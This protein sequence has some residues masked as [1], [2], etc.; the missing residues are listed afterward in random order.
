MND[1]KD[2]SI[3]LKALSGE[4]NNEMFL[5]TSKK[6]E[7]LTSNF[8]YSHIFYFGKKKK[9]AGFKRYDFDF[10]NNTDG[11]KRW[12][13]PSD[14]KK[15]TFLNFYN[16]SSLKS[17][18]YRLVLSFC[19]LLKL[20]FLIRS[21]RFSFFSKAEILPL[22]LAQKNGCQN[23]SIFTGTVGPN[24]KIVIELNDH[25][26]SKYFVKIPLNGISEDL[27]K[28]ELSTL[29]LLNKLKI[30]KFEIPSMQ[31][32]DEFKGALISNV[33]PDN[34]NESTAIEDFHIEVLDDLYKN[35]KY[36]YT[37]KFSPF[38]FHLKS[39]MERAE[40]NKYENDLMHEIGGNLNKLYSKI[41]RDKYFI[42]GLSHGDFTPWN[43]YKKNNKLFI[44]DWELSS[45]HRP[46][47]FDVFHY[48]FQ[49]E[50]LL[51]KNNF[52]A[53][54]TEIDRITKLSSFKKISKKYSINVEANYRLYLLSNIAYYLNIYHKQGPLHKQAFWLME[55]W[56]DALKFEIAQASAL[57]YREEFIIEFFKKIESFNYVILKKHQR[58]SE[59]I[60]GNSD[61][62]ILL[63]K[64]DLGFFVELVNGSPFIEKSVV[65]KKSFMQTIMIYF[66]DGSYLSLDLLF[67]FK[68]KSLEYLEAE[69][70]LHHSIMGPDQLK[71][72]H[73]VSDFEYS[74]LFYLLN[75]KD[76][77]KRHQKFFL[78]LEQNDQKILFEY[79]NRK[80]EI[81]ASSLPDLFENHIRYHNDILKKIKSS[82]A[83][84]LLK[85]L[86]NS[87]MY[88]I[89][90]FK[91]LFN[92]QSLTIS[93]SGVDG[94]GKSTIINEVKNHLQNKYR[95]RVIVLRHRPQIIPI[96]SSF[97]YGRKQ[98]ELMAAETLPR[99][100]KN[101]S[102]LGSF[103]RFSYYFLDYLFGQVY[104]FVRY[105]LRDYIILYD[106]FYFDFINDDKR[107]NIQLNSSFIKSLYRFLLKPS[108]NIFL[109]AE[110]A[111]I[112]S[113][114]QE[115]D[116]NEISELN[117][118]YIQLFDSY[119]QK[120]R[121]EK[122]ISIENNNKSETLNLIINEYLKLA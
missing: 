58:L 90:L 107:S 84:S 78:E 66:K 77:D 92:N 68:R 76:T 16:N 120:S 20:K 14:L 82:V 111:I 61:I 3:L 114:K 46:L 60:K 72:P 121:P 50:V 38:Y 81:N 86:R 103:L 19:F 67:A 15:A 27:I 22:K 57:S 47:L 75:R 89:D 39:M 91:Q 96:L 33:K 44:Y 98:A 70:V 110:P 40:N 74:Y 97:K 11:S 42:F 30:S 8:L 52:R 43:F 83:N 59:L 112:L 31:W 119:T 32:V 85:R 102:V 101:R 116:E 93:F 4:E 36:N 10:I 9:L 80:Y 122:Y 2:L 6:E 108:L 87:I 24:R 79:M 5:M 53:I 34:V 109:Y 117:E 64:Q 17:I 95:K 115:M 28:N 105:T 69:N 12:V 18:I 63:Q 35:S 21:G 54:K 94:A 73:I 13:Y 45:Q 23:F 26:K 51:K 29:N 104:V 48:V 25:I 113:R 1:Y 118:K 71:I 88:S 106:R 7:L 99:M 100:G 37:L 62:D 41:E 65:Q 55:V 49:S 56:N